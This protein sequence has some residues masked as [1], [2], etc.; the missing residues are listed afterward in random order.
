M[1]RNISRESVNSADDGYSSDNVVKSPQK[2]TFD[3]QNRE[4]KEK[5]LVEKLLNNSA[6]GVIYTGK[7]KIFL[8]Y[9]ISSR[10]PK[11]GYASSSGETNSK[12]TNH[13]THRYSATGDSLSPEG[14]RSWR[15]LSFIG[16]F[17]TS[18]QLGSYLGTEQKLYRSFWTKFAV[19]SPWWRRSEDNF[20]SSGS[21]FDFAGQTRRFSPWHQRRKYT[22]R[23][24]NTSYA[25]YRLWLCNCLW[26]PELRRADGNPRVLPSR[27]LYNSMLQGGK[28]NSMDNRYSDV[29]FADWWHPLWH[30]KTDYQLFKNQGKSTKTNR[31]VR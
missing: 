21:N 28:I 7:S 23:Y 29:R 26:K 1:N 20:A 2:E 13:I 16:L 5:Y 24:Q 12:I 10:H 11:I 15:S 9:L 3:K 27:I 19:W 4:F 14:F 30:R 25:T 18:N 6:N 17:R 22:G 31:T 8:H